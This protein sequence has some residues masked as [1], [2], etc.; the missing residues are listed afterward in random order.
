MVASLIYF[1]ANYAPEI[2]LI[3]IHI[4]SNSYRKYVF[5]V[6]ID[7]KIDESLISKSMW[8]RWNQF[9]DQLDQMID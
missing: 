5:F 3:K 6:K 7:S 2:R 9:V 8:I 1:V 4:V